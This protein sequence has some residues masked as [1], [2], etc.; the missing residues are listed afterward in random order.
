MLWRQNTG[1]KRM[2]KGK[3]LTH[4]ETINK[5]ETDKAFRKQIFKGLLDHIRK[6]SS[7][8]CYGPL[9]ESSIRTYIKAYPDEFVGA[10]LELAQRDAKD[11]W[12]GLGRRQAEGTCLGNSRSWYYNMSNRFGWSDRQRVDVDA[13]HEISVSVVSYASKK[14]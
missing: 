12:E 6:G 11:Y 5:L 7:L 10:E 1:A 13:K 2:A 14:L 3:K 8:D 9:S 4:K